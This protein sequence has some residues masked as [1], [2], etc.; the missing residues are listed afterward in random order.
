[1]FREVA[2][3]VVGLGLIGGIGSVTYNDDG[4]TNVTI[5]GEDG[6]KQ[7]VQLEGDGP[8]FTCPDG[9][10]ARI[11]EVDVESGRIKLT[12]QKVEDELDAI[13][14]KYPKSKR[15]PARVIKRYDRLVK[16]DKKLIKAFNA[17]VDEHNKIID[18]ECE[19]A[20]E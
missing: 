9:V 7:S 11:E 15:P 1:M 4:S 5:T 2:A 6:K 19:P 10:T 20:E 12:L 3:G 8:A 14:R 17:S 18:E 16:Q 13:Q